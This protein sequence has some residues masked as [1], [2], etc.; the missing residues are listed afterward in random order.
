MKS[1]ILTHDQMIQIDKEAKRQKSKIEENKVATEWKILP[2]VKYCEE[3]SS[4][5]SMSMYSIDSREEDSEFISNQT[6]TVVLHNAPLLMHVE[7]VHSSPI[8]EKV[9]SERHFVVQEEYHPS[10]YN[11]EEIFGAFTFNL[12]RKEFSRKRVRKVKQ[13]DGNFEEMQEDEVLF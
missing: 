9:P 4:S 1:K 3:D 5:S 6:L 12:H 13:S 10:S 2:K 11:I 8:T 7:E